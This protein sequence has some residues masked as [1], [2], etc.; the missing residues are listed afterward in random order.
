ML[1]NKNAIRI[2][3]LVEEFVKTNNLTEKVI[4]EKIRI[5]WSKITSLSLSKNV[6]VVELNNGILKLSTDVASWRL[7]I[8]LHKIE[9]VSLV[10]N[11]LEL[12]VVKSVEI[13]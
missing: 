8:S 4:C 13:H 10:N 7:E 1:E 2:S 3:N 12:E 11:F 6:K 9:I 5:N